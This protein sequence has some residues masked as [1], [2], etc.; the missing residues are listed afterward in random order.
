MTS[1]LSFFLGLSLIVKSVN[2]SYS[3][4]RKKQE[5]TIFKPSLYFT[6]T[7]RMS[8]HTLEEQV[9]A[10]L[11]ENDKLKKENEEVCSLCCYCFGLLVYSF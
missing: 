2:T 7:I 3:E 10:L 11:D 4:K 5:Q 8:D 1:F 6:S 9:K